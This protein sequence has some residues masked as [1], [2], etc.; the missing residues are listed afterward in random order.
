MILKVIV[1]KVVAVGTATEVT[2]TRVKAFTAVMKMGPY[3]KCSGWHVRVDGGD[4]GAAEERG[5]GGAGE[6]ICQNF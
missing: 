1:A 6:C 3:V 5:R 2:V 4:G